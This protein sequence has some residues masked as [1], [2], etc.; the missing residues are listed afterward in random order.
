M[1][2]YTTYGKVFIIT[3]CF[4]IGSCVDVERQCLEGLLF[5]Y[6]RREALRTGL[7]NSLN[8]QEVRVTVVR[9]DIKVTHLFERKKFPVQHG[10]Q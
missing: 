10:K 3:T 4:S 8:K 1:A 7:W 5:V 2:S 9:S 6:H